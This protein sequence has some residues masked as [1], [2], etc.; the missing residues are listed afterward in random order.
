MDTFKMFA[1]EPLFT[2]IHSYGHF[3]SVPNN[4]P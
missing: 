1:V 4:F 2:V 3:F